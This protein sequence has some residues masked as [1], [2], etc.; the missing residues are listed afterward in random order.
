ML[1]INFAGAE[2]EYLEV[3]PKEEKYNGSYRRTLVV[4]CP[5]DAISVDALNAMLTEKNLERI[6]LTNTE[7]G[8]MEIHEGYVLKMSCGIKSVEVAPETL[9]T[10]ALHEE[11]LMFQLGKRTYIEE[12]LH[13]LGL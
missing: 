10:P 5:P 9:D 12:Q 8:A 13:K 6:T 1:K 2:F 3:A 11:R 4:S 7:T